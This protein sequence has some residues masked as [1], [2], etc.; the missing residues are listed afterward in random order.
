MQPTIEADLRAARLALER[1]AA[2]EGLPANAAQGLS[3]VTRSLKRLEACWFRMLPYLSTENASTVALLHELAPL[4]P[5][6]LN[7]DIAALGDAPVPVA[8]ADALDAR[9]ANELN[10]TLRDLLARAIG[11]FP[12]GEEGA[13]ARARVTEHFGA[14]M[15]LRPW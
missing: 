1:I 14:T 7:R 5:A 9:K 8:D 3:E 10:G 2:E 11:T 6:D 13:A 15:E 4:L 12:P